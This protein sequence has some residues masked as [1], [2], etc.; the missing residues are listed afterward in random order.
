M[1]VKQCAIF[2]RWCSLSEAPSTTS[3]ATIM[4]RRRLGMGP[5]ELNFCHPQRPEPRQSKSTHEASLTKQLSPITI[6]GDLRGPIN[7]ASTVDENNQSAAPH[8]AGHQFGEA[9]KR[10]EGVEERSQLRTHKSQHISFVEENLRVIHELIE[11]G[12]QRN[13][14]CKVNHIIKPKMHQI[15]YRN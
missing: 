8:H 7:H 5:L 10:A 6:E 14:V 1:I 4:F 11:K 15:R 2:R 9:Y 3:K 12:G 13:E